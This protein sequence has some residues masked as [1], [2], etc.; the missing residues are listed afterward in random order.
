MEQE[1]MIR[2]HLWHNPWLEPPYAALLGLAEE[3]DALVLHQG[4]DDTALY[5]LALNLRRRSAPCV[6]EAWFSF[7]KLV[8]GFSYKGICMYD[9]TDIMKNNQDPD[10]VYGR[11][12][13]LRGGPVHYD[14]T[15][16]L[17]NIRLGRSDHGAYFYACASDS[18]HLSLI[19]GGTH[20]FADCGDMLHHVLYRIGAVYRA[21]SA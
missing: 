3:I 19:N 7:L 6:P 11:A 15:R 8:A 17:Q 21:Y 13:M 20:S 12:G 2:T 14:R 16:W 4:A 10:P 5:Y 1:Q 9:L 18:Y